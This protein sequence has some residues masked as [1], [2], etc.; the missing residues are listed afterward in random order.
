MARKL[1][2]AAIAEGNTY[3]F[4]EEMD[5]VT[6]ASYFLSHEAFTLSARDGTDGDR[7]A[8]RGIFYIK[9]NFPGRCSHICNGGFVVDESARG[10]GVCRRMGEAFLMLAPILGYRAAM[11][12][13]CFVTNVAS[14]HLWR[15]LGFSELAVIP[16][17]GNLKTF[18][19]TDAIMFR[20]ELVSA[21]VGDTT[22]HTGSGSNA[23]RE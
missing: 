17:A 18:G 11:F 6:F 9:P 8:V 23:I 2:N 14:C 19:F 13:L 10:N 5:D 22:S 12:N 1:L 20:K 15:S 7:K 4:D 16:K 21:P 3:P